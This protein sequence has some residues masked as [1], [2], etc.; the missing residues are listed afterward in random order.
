MSTFCEDLTREQ[1]LN[2][3]RQRRVDAVVNRIFDEFEDECTRRECEAD[4]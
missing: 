2:L 4:R 1:M 3:A